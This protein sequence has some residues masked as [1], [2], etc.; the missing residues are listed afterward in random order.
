MRH[1]K[2]FFYDKIIVASMLYCKLHTLF[3]L[4]ALYFQ[5][6]VTVALV[7]IFN[8]RQVVRVGVLFLN[9][10]LKL[11]VLKQKQL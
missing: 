4:R 2:I 9:E 10:C 8:F 5:A 6:I 11:S 1:F 3:L 7:L